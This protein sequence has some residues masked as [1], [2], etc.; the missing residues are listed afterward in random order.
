MYFKFYIIDFRFNALKY[1]K[2]E[3]VPEKMQFH[4]FASG[5]WVKYKEINV[6]K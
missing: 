5:V 4:I 3:A 2:N 6:E 1:D